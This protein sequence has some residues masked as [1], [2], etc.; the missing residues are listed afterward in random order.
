VFG[1]LLVLGGGILTPLLAQVPET[2]RGSRADETVRVRLV[3]LAITARD[4]G[5]NPVTDLT[6]DEIAVKEGGRKMR[7]AFLEPFSKE[8]QA[9]E[10]PDVRLFVGAPGAT[11]STVLS[12][13]LEPRHV[14]LFIDVENDYR[15]LKQEAIEDV[16][17]FL[18]D[19]LGP[20]YRASVVAYDGEFHVESGFTKSRDELASAVMRA[21]S[22]IWGYTCEVT[23]G[24]TG[25]DDRFGL[26][27]YAYFVHIYAYENHAEH[28]RRVAGEGQTTERSQGKDRDRSRRARSPG[29]ARERTQAGS[30]RWYG[31]G[32]APGAASTLPKGLVV[33]VDTSVWIDH[34]RRGN[35][36][37]A[38][39]LENGEVEYH[40]FVVGELACGILARRGEILSLME[41]L[42]RVLEAEHEE[43]LSL[44]ES[45]QLSGRG[46][47]WI[48]VHLLASAMLQRTTLWTL[49]K[50]LAEQASRLDVLFE[51]TT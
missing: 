26:D 43:V 37:L 29:C 27:G 6:A 40:P 51:P 44:V 48:D 32:S 10:A 15:L 30:P 7:V 4:R 47:G 31:K 9:E 41:S 22:P 42:P 46:L 12:A 33:L 24:L 35:A 20:E 49:D 50:R 5:G 39:R 13:A 38:T 2:P 14:I 11:A 28:R 25:A 45:R 23:P 8:H 36:Q 18:R 21:P 34:L 19:E 16:L 17:R 3:Q 1:P